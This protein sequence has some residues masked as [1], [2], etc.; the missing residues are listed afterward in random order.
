M[1][2]PRH[3]TRNV[4]HTSTHYLRFGRPLEPGMERED[5][6]SEISSTETASNA[7]FRSSRDA[8]RNFL[9]EAVRST[10]AEP[11]RRQWLKHNRY[12]AK[13]LK[14]AIARK[15]QKLLDTTAS[16]KKSDDDV[17]GSSAPPV[18]PR[19]VVVASTAA[20]PGVNP[21]P[22]AFEDEVCHS[23]TPAPSSLVEGAASQP[24]HYVTHYPWLSEL[25]GDDTAGV[26]TGPSSRCI[27]QGSWGA[28][29]PAGYL[30]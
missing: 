9:V 24:S 21:S 20:P 3:S 27:R 5:G 23:T 12:Y 18:K 29:F 22:N 19:S 26:E 28:A 6:T 1:I 7:F 15:Q 25:A 10:S 8:I 16:A 2:V 17:T 13:K 30:E 11:L 4:F 14:D